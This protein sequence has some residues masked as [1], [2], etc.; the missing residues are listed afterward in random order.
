MKLWVNKPKKKEED[1][2]HKIT[3]ILFSF[4]NHFNKELKPLSLTNIDFVI[5]L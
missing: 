5:T 2:C 3:A 4:K 1:K